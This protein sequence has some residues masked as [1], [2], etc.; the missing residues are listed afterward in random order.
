MV[1]DKI[2]YATNLKAEAR[3]RIR[4]V[5]L[6]SCCNSHNAYKF[7]PLI[8]GL[9]Q[10]RR[11]K[12]LISGLFTKEES[13]RLSRLF[14]IPSRY[15]YN[16]R[17]KLRQLI[18]DFTISK[19]L[20]K[21]KAFLSF[22]KQHGESPELHFIKEESFK[23]MFPLVILSDSKKER[24]RLSEGLRKLGISPI[25]LGSDKQLEGEDQSAKKSVHTKKMM[26]LSDNLGTVYIGSSS[27]LPETFDLGIKMIVV[28]GFPRSIDHL[29]QIVRFD[30][31]KQHLFFTDKEFLKKRN[32]LLSEFIE[33]ACLLRLCKMM[34]RL[35]NVSSLRMTQ[36]GL[37]SIH[38]SGRKSKASYDYPEN[39]EFKV[40]KLRQAEL[41]KMLNTSKAE[42]LCWTINKLQER[43]NFNLMSSC[44]VSLKITFTIPNHTKST[45]RGI[46]RI[47][48]HGKFSS[49]KYRLDLLSMCEGV[50]EKT[51]RLLRDNRIMLDWAIVEVVTQSL[52]AQ[53]QKVE[54]LK[55]KGILNI[56][57]SDELMFFKPKEGL[58]D[59]QI[60]QIIAERKHDETNLLQK[61]SLPRFALSDFLG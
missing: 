41:N 30:G 24:D 34:K 40:L 13:L 58:T 50:K 37:S 52:R 2:E 4:L 35:S 49:G 42:P 33:P 51:K 11:I 54:E 48:S 1:N 31:A 32:S 16:K 15:C 10:T 57:V 27:R 19:D 44:P 14:G 46:K 59:V 28:N 22:L 6:D 21:T 29:L 61:V 23:I 20:D 8:Q 25:H 45:N 17:P 56:E 39:K 3:K 60:Y 47:I 5:V 38:S 18:K 26:S 55:E 43:G 9:K 12:L 53:L 36:E 7:S